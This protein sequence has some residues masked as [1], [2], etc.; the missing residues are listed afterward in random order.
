MPRGLRGAFSR[1]AALAAFG[2]L[3]AA[4]YAEPA[5][6]VVVREDASGALEVV[7]HRRVELSDLASSSAPLSKRLERGLTVRMVDKDSGAVVFATRAASSQWL[8]GEF[9]AKGH[10]DGHLYSTQS[11]E[12]VVRVPARRSSV[13]RLESDAVSV[14]E[15]RAG[16][17][18]LDVDLDT[19]ETKSATPL[20]PGYATGSLA[21]TGDPVNRLDLLVVAEGYTSAQQAQF[22]TDAT[23]LMERFFSISPYSDFR[24]LTNVRWLFVPS[25]QSGADKPACPETP[26]SPVVAVD[27]AFDATF[28]S[29]GLRR[30]V[31][32]N[33]T[34]VLTAAGAVPDWD[35]ILVLVND[36]EYGGSGGSASVATLHALSSEIMQH[37]FGHSF[38]GL[39]DE[40]E[41]PYPGYPTCT[42]A[43]G[44]SSP[45][46]PNVTDRTDRT[47]IKWKGW[48]AGDT[49]VPTP[50]PL[51]DPLAAGSWVG[52]RFQSSGMY[53]G[54]YNGIM[55]ELGQPFGDVEIEA[56]VKRLYGGGWGSP[57]A[58]VSLIEPGS[59]PVSAS[60]TAVRGSSVAFQAIAVGSLS[61]RGLTAT[62][63]VDGAVARSD[64]TAH[65]ATQSFSYVV[66]DTGTHTIELVVA[67]NTP[68]LLQ[69][70]T[71]S[72]QWTVTGTTASG[73]VPGAPTLTGSSAGDRRATVTF[74]A[75]ANDGGSPILRYTT[76]CNPGANA[77]DSSG[78]PAS[79]TGLSNGVNYSCSVT[80]TNANGTGP[81]SGSANVTPVGGSAP[82]L[83]AVMS[84]K[85]HGA[86]GAFDIAIDATKPVSGAVTVEPRALGGGFLIV[87]QFD[88]TVTSAGTVS[89]V[90]A[91]SNPM[92]SA[93]ASANG[94]EIVVMLTGIPES[95]RATVSLTGVNGASATYSIC[96]G[97]LVGDVD[98]SRNVVDTDLQAVKA[99]VGQPVDAA[100]FLYDL[101][102]NGAISSADLLMAKGRAG[103]GI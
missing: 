73:N 98:S 88:K 70:A 81:S 72:R 53:R 47:Q 27:T 35:R 86:A 31:T 76:T 79:V 94:S 5:H 2:G 23:N 40:Y 102:A 92:G 12:Y 82:V 48:I 101:D 33:M 77:V 34:K 38:T 84:R 78:S 15:K 29:S 16:R 22:V 55:R 95:R 4:A 46:E 28:C 52:A 21:T 51:S 25:N 67:D 97:F 37:E 99:R 43:A 66:P 10:I 49:A 6:Y 103:V 75:P 3:A 9:H 13:L 62:W 32:V 14:Q 11:R 87:F 74:S 58:G 30:M 89:V 54:C 17:R 85:A 69:A 18:M 20:P 83:V 19:Y 60:I 65:G 96:L 45:C 64:G 100:T 50:S 36:T 24:H 68:M 91:S 26:G 80:A 56:F 41:T 63:R 39:A 44:S 42:D 1:L 61:A 71:S 59:S 8:R 90:D 93:S 7:S 57:A